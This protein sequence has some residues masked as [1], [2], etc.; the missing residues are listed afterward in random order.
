[1]GKATTLQHLQL[2]DV[3][4]KMST[5]TFFDWGSFEV[6]PS[7]YPALRRLAQLLD[8]HKELKVSIEGHCGLE[9]IY[10]MASARHAKSYSRERAISVRRALEGEAQ[11]IHV[12][13]KDRITVR[14]WG[15]SRPLVWAMIPGHEPELDAS[16]EAGRKKQYEGSAKNRRVEWYLR[17]G[18]FEVP[19]RRRRSE[20]PVR[21]GE[22]PMS[23]H[24]EDEEEEEQ[25]EDSSE[26]DFPPSNVVVVQL[27]NGQR[28]AIPL[29]LY[30]RL[31]QQQDENEADEEED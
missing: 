17:V 27:P 23:D 19:R 13:L 9:A 25:E 14:G 4:A 6:V 15:Y 7:A 5:N 2:A 26:E 30:N 22:Q 21:P 12:N 20:I 24:S 10:R 11:Q 8:Q 18:D 1:M 28:F 31:Q 3:M 29:A 16:T